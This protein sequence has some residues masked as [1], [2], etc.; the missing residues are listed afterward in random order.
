[1]NLLSK[2]IT[3]KNVIKYVPEIQKF[4][5]VSTEPFGG[6]LEKDGQRSLKPNGTRLK[7]EEVRIST[8]CIITR[9]MLKF[10]LTE[11]TM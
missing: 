4:F 6:F 7:S 1:M 2:E 3:Y 10:L 9:N 11:I 8:L 5:G